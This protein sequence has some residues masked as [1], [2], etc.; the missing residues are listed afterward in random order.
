VKVVLDAGLQKTGSKSRQY[1]FTVESGGT[2]DSALYFPSTGRDGRWHRHLYYSVIAGDPK[3][4]EALRQELLTISA[5]LVVI[6]YEEFYKLSVEH[7]S[8]LKE[9]LPSLEVII[10]LRRQDQLVNSYYNQLHKSHHVTLAELEQYESRLGSKIED[11]DY[12]D[13]LLRWSTG[14]GESAVHPVLY[15]KGKSSIDSFLGACSA[16]V[17]STNNSEKHMNL[18]M[19]AYGLSVLR[20]VKRA[21]RDEKEL[22]TLVTR[23][24]EALRPH[25]LASDGGDERYLMSLDK[26]KELMQHYVESNEWVRKLWF[27]EQE[28]L[29][30][31][32]EPGIY[33]PLNVS[34]G[35]GEAKRIIRRH[36]TKVLVDHAAR[37]VTTFGSSV[38]RLVRGRISMVDN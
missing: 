2:G 37:V 8:L 10:F 30:T 27:P 17:D 24:H 19:D 38:R 11:Y 4:L 15:D 16:V 28:T 7:I 32:L 34:V 9:Y 31:T 13:I 33:S 5:P 22:W 23:A 1:F 18:A 36:R 26:R 25:F 20:H 3:L 12:R 14:L 6:S 35:H 21:A 29:F